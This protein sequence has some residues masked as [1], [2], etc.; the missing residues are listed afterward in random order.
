MIDYQEP[1]AS[2]QRSSI[3]RNASVCDRTGS[4]LLRNDLD[5][6]E[7]PPRAEYRDHGEAGVL[8]PV[9]E[10]P[11]RRQMRDRRDA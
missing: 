8:A 5:R 4:L 1:G 6:V 10:R 7:A 2:A 3:A 9:R 11:A